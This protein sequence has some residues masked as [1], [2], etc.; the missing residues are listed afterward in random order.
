MTR[1]AL[2]NGLSV[3]ANRCLER[4]GIP[5]EKEAVSQALK[6]GTLW[7]FLRPRNYGKKTHEEVCRWAG[8]DETTLPLYAGK[9]AVCPHCGHG[10]TSADI[11]WQ[12]V[13]RAS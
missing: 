9:R 13:E 8:V 4:A 10:L 1:K 11:K 2:S 7:P 12:T 3:R 6:T 5:A